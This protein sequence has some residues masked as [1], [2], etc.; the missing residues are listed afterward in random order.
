MICNGCGKKLDD[1][2]AVCPVCGKKTVG[3]TAYAQA[4][5]T[6]SG[7]CPK[8]GK[9]LINGICMICSGRTSPA[10]A[11]APANTVTHSSER[12]P[13]SGNSAAQTVTT[14][15]APTPG[16]YDRFAQNTVPNS[17]GSQ[18]PQAIPYSF[19]SA[20][21]NAAPLKNTASAIT[22]AVSVKTRLPKK[23]II[24]AFGVLLAVILTLTTVLNTKSNKIVGTWKAVEAYDSQGNS[25]TLDDNYNITLKFTKKGV[26]E[27]TANGQTATTYYKIDGDM[28]SFSTSETIVGNYK[29][30]KT[31]QIVIEKI[32]LTKLV[33]TEAKGSV[34]TL[35][36]KRV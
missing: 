31:E 16:S 3:H 15:P 1:G 6:P 34:S 33:L 24:I 19:S 10:A 23:V 20:A 9:K 11:A 21:K 8:C 12:R 18:Q 32:T 29:R 13:D 5:A 2:T 22:N 7:I 4:A 30:E 26:M 25:V 28:L 17:P 27:V 36:L 14:K 35:V